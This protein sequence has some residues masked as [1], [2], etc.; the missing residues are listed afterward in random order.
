MMDDTLMTYAALD[1]PRVTIAGPDVR[2]SGRTAESMGLAL[3]ELATNAIKFG[4]LSPS[5]ECGTLDIRWEVRQDRLLLE[6]LE[7]GIAV[8]SVAPLRIGFGREY[9]EQGLPYQLG[10]ETGFE[11][12]AGR[13]RCTFAIS[14][15]DQDSLTNDG[16]IGDLLR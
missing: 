14:L 9:I 1:H 6:W 12:S 5:N 2:L 3:H 15:S 7:A 10:G 11:L 13:L 16:A 4:V 8:V